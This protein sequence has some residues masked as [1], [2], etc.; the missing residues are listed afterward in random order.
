MGEGD[1]SSLCQGDRRMSDS[2]PAPTS[3]VSKLSA[4]RT[5]V[6][7]R[8]VDCNFSKPYPPNGDEKRWWDRL[9]AALGTTSSDFVNATLSPKVAPA[10]LLA[11][12][13]ARTIRRRFGLASRFMNS[14]AA[15]AFF[16]LIFRLDRDALRMVTPRPRLPARSAGI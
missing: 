14:E 16:Q 5:R 11:R 7:L 6:K 9:K 3:P 2:V 13:S 15:S 8:R 4:R 12:A 10:P 1:V